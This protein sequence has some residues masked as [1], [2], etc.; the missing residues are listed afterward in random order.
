MRLGLRQRMWHWSFKTSSPVR[1]GTWR[2]PFVLECAAMSGLAWI[3]GL[4]GG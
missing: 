3:I 2:S 4:V 1:Y